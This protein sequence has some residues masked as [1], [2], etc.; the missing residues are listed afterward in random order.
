MIPSTRSAVLVSRLT[1]NLVTRTSCPDLPSMR[2]TSPEDRWGGV[3]KE[4]SSIAPLVMGLCLSEHFLEE[5]IQNVIAAQEYTIV[6]ILWSSILDHLHSY[7]HI[8]HKRFVVLS[9]SMGK[10]LEEDMVDP[11]H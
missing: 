2:T 3:H 7:N 5:Y 1:L 8:D 11:S 4:A 10:C 9:H 6:E